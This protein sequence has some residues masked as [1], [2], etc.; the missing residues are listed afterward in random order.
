[1]NTFRFIPLAT[2]LLISTVTRAQ[3]AYPVEL[4]G[5]LSQ[6]PVPRKSNSCY[7]ACKKTTDGRTGMVSIED[8]G[9]VFAA[10]KD[11]LN[12]I[13]QASVA[14]LQVPASTSATPAEAPSRDQ[15]AMITYLSQVQATCIK[16]NQLCSQLNAKLMELDKS[17]IEAVR[18]GPDCPLIRGGAIDCGCEISRAAAYETK[19]VAARDVYLGQAAALF[20]QYLLRI[21]PLIGDVDAAMIKTKYGEAISNPSYKQQV[22]N[23]QRQ[24]IAPMSSIMGSA[25]ALWEDAAKQ[26]ADLVNAKSGATKGCY[27][28]K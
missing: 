15:M 1:M 27:G 16:I 28:R 18:P 3:Q 11:K 10:L 20:D 7:E 6:M 12:K 5:L 13:V 22:V 9:P 14:G 21:R 26:Y 23:L 8:N 19:R 17:P 4:G 25:G 24:I 2:L